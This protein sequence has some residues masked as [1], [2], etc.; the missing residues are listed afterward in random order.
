M[1]PISEFDEPQIEFSVTDTGIGMSSDQLSKL[2]RPFTQ[3]DSS[4]ARRFGGT[5]LGLTICKRIASLLGGD[6]TVSSTPGI[7]TTFR[8]RL[9]TGPLAGVPMI[10][11][12]AGQSNVESTK[13]TA[14]ETEQEPQLNCRILLAEDGVDN[15]RLISF[16]LKRAGADVTLVDNGVAALEA[17]LAARAVGDPFDVIVTDIQ[18][19]KMDGYALTRRLRAEHYTGPIIA[20]TANAMGGD[21]ERCLAAGCDDYAAKPIHRLELLSVIARHSAG[22]PDD[23]PNE[24]TQLDA[25]P[26][27]TSA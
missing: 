8:V 24:S 9:P 2:F 12:P 21:R 6:V 18:M 11:Q 13:P 4:T 7:G 26:D 16:V 3:A 10:E 1:L 17:A 14:T 23:L 25:A 19:P 5:G 20:L 15:Q 27:S 22:S